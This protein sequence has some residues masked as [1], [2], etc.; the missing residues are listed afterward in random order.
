MSSER[1][2]PE[3][4]R[5]RPGPRRARGMPSGPAEVRRAVLDAA[6]KLFSERGVADVALREIA[7]EARVNLGLISRYIG[8]RDDLIRAV[9]ADLTEQLVGEIH[10]DPTGKKG[11]E[12]DTV[13]GRWTKVLTHLVIADPQAAIEIGSRPVD[14][15]RAVIEQSYDQSRESSALRAA[16]L[17]ASAIGWRMFEP[18]LIAAAGL[19]E[20][21]IE[22]VREELTRTHRRLGATPFP[23]PPDPQRQR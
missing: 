21:P 12:P 9:F 3:V 11:F 7:D 23:S 2:E 5:R 22:D 8:Q 13:M 17:M 10:D 14:E 18:Y 16:Q 15:L 6:A 19:E 20:V 1:A 4:S